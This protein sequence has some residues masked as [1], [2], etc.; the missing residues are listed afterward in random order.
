MVLDPLPVICR[1][2]TMYD[3][4]SV[5]ITPD[6]LDERL[7]SYLQPIY[8]IPHMTFSSKT[9]DRGSTFQFNYN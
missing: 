2:F 3:L 1:P 8:H 7:D 6:P 4:S 5:M 9:Y